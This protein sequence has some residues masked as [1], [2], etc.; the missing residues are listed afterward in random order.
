MATEIERKFLVEGAR[1]AEWGKGVVIQQGYLARGEEAT[2]RV[3]VADENGYLTIKGKT[4]GISRQEFEYAIPVEEAR[5]LLTLCEGGIISK[6]RWRVPYEG[7]IWEVDVFDGE[8]AG[9]II[10]EIEL[11]SEQEIFTKPPWISDEVS[12]DP[13][14]FN[15]ALSRYPFSSW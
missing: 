12:D 4:E 3:R 5:T 10:A 14:Y 15:G 11:E 7:K 6:T 8:N 9:L 13:R 1:I 2:C